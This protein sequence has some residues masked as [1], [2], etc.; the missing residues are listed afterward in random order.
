MSEY[1]YIL[2]SEHSGGLSVWGSLMTDENIAQ[3]EL[4]LAKKKYPTYKFKIQYRESLPF[5]DL[6]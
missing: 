1:E 6:T 3:L 5:K 4:E 2:V